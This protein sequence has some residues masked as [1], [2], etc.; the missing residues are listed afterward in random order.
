MGMIWSVGV[1]LQCDGLEIF[2]VWVWSKFQ[3]DIYFGSIENCCNVIFLCFV[4][5]LNL[6]CVCCFVSVIIVS[7]TNFVFWLH[8]RVLSSL[9]MVFLEANW[10][11]F[12]LSLVANVEGLAH[13][14]IWVG[15]ESS[16]SF[17]TMS[18]LFFYLRFLLLL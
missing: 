4:C 7:I 11:F 16:W 1:Y 12:L 3:L 18:W 17:I 13:I 10:L 6:C 2:G 8:F 5:I 15:L 14:L 9:D